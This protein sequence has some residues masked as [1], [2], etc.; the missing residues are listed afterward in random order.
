MKEPPA[1]AI[2]IVG[3]DDM[4]AMVEKLEHRGLGRK[5]RGEGEAGR[6][7]FEFGEGVFEGGAGRIARARILPPVFTPGDD[8]RKVDVAKIGVMTARSSA[9]AFACHESHASQDP[10]LFRSCRCQ[11]LSVYLPR[12]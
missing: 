12:R 7:A 2:K 3:G 6:A 11:P 5:T 1:S 4:R 8:C 9:R 10:R